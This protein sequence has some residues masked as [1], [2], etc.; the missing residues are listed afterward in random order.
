M[1][2][3][4]GK[5]EHGYSDTT[6]PLQVQTAMDRMTAPEKFQYDFF[7]EAFLLSTHRQS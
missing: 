3:S 1:S 7:I 5:T 6:H 2:L 4:N